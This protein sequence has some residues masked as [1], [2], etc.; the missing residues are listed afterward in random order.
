M[1]KLTLMIAIALLFLPGLV[2]AQQRSASEDE[3]ALSQLGRDYYE[4]WESNSIEKM[5]KILHPKA[6]LFLAGSKNDLVA[7]TPDHLYAAFK[8]NGRQNYGSPVRP[9]GSIH[10]SRPQIIGNVATMQLEMAYPSL[11]VTH[12]FSLM[13]FAEGWKVV[14]RVTAVEPQQEANARQP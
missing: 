10:I 3:A 7:Q 5:K 13:K 14:S 11:K 2:Q 9:K 6:R 12:Q 1:N 8:S 4:A